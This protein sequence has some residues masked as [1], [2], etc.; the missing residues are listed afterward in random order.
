MNNFNGHACG[1]FGLEKRY[2]QDFCVK[3]PHPIHFIQVIKS[4]IILMDRHG[5]FFG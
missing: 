2:I 3:I 4:G 1:H 5:N